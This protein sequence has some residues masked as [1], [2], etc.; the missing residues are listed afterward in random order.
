MQVPLL[1][2]GLF[3]GSLDQLLCFQVATPSARREVY[4]PS[5]AFCMMSVTAFPLQFRMILLL[6]KS[7]ST[8]YLHGHA[9]HKTHQPRKP[10]I[11]RT[12]GW[13]RKQYVIS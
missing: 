8:T 10:S 7:H 2:L 5:V 11:C 3:F 1:S 13:K 4:L 6:T 12:C 9:R